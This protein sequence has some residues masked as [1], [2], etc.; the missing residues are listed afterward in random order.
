ML[1]ALARNTDSFPRFR[2]VKR[3]RVVIEVNQFVRRGRRYDQISGA[4]SHTEPWRQIA[5]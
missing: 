4:E 2:G 5:K 3:R 1:M